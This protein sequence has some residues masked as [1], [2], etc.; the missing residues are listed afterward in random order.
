MSVQPIINTKNS[1]P[2]LSNKE[3]AALT[4][5]KN[6]KISQ[7]LKENKIPLITVGAAALWS[8]AFCANAVRGNIKNGQ[9]IEMVLKSEFSKI[10]N[11]FP[12]DLKYYKKLAQALN[13]PKGEEFKLNSIV[14]PQQ[15][16]KILQDA[17]EKDF[18]IGDNL[19]CVEDLS[20]RINLH[21]HTQASD[22]KMSIAE[23]LDNAVLYANK[24]AKKFPNEKFVV[25]I[26][27]HDTTL[28]AQ[29]AIELISQDPYK[30]RNLKFVAG[31]EI[32]VIHSNPFNYKKPICYELLNYS[33][34]PFESLY[35]NLLKDLRKNRILNVKNYIEEMNQLYP[36]LNLSSQ[37]VFDF[38]PNLKR[39]TTNY[40]IDL[41][42][43]YILQK[44]SSLPNSNKEFIIQI[45]ETAEKY[46]TSDIYISADNL[47]EHF[48]ECAQDGFFAVAHPARISVL[49]VNC[50]PKFLKSLEFE[51]ETLEQTLINEIYEHLIY[52]NK[53]LLC[54]N[55]S[56]Y[57]AYPS[58]LNKDLIEYTQNLASKKSFNL[59][60]TGGIDAHDSS[61]FV[62]KL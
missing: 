61:I 29:K 11:E 17:T 33:I 4:S 7:T 51:S 28:G 32:S 54:A 55:E 2:V 1:Y 23:F 30:Y 20:H 21:N 27:D 5:K 16:K 9:T 41:A 48:E 26:T 35:C 42:K 19:M 22:G 40:T 57:Q 39:G 31:C 43:K 49:P 25:A 52:L 8:I 15:L 56:Y 13:L 36:E 47:F 58:C 60:S 6:N 59:L 62:R 37:E 50:Q 44:Y 53:E 10:I 34:N 14:G 46:K 12:D 3:S 45:L 38:K 18:S 24:R